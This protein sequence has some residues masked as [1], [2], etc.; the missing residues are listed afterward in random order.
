MTQIQ[1]SGIIKAEAIYKM[2]PDMRGGGLGIRRDCTLQKIND[3]VYITLLTSSGT[4]E[5]ILEV[6]SEDLAR[7]HE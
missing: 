2:R 1:Q 6:N 5:F 4:R 7:L 3:Q